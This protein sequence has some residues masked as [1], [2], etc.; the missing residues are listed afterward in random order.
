MTPDNN[1]VQ[2]S[3]NVWSR[4]R[5]GLDWAENG[6]K[7][8]GRKW[9][10]VLKTAWNKKKFNHVSAKPGTTLIN[11]YNILTALCYTIREHITMFR[12]YIV[13]I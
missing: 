9:G 13:T 11:D 8:V 3:L 4:E 12:L 1:K 6:R 7:W 5:P 2:R 10:Q